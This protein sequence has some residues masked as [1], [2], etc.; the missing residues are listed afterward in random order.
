MKHCD[1]LSSTAL[2]VVH[3]L[4]QLRP[5]CS[6]RTRLCFE[7]LLTDW[8]RLTS[9][10][11]VRFHRGST[12][13]AAPSVV[14]AG[15]WNAV[16]VAHRATMIDARGRKPYDRRTSTFKPR[17]MSTGRGVCR[18]T[19]RARPNSGSRCRR[20]YVAI[21]DLVVNHRQPARLSR[22]RISLIGRSR[23]F[24]PVRTATRRLR[25]PFRLR[26]SSANSASTHRL[27]FDVSS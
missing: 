22:S 8:R 17:R 14:G 2:L 26:Q 5:S 24:V 23:T 25:R 10:V 19:P 13:N 11:Y 20:S 16:T 27:T 3:R 6:K 1:K 12:L 7:E 21:G 18:V 4:L 9:F 15:G